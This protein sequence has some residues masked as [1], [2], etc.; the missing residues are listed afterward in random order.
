MIVVRYSEI[1]LKGTRARRMMENRL[2]S[3]IR[4]GLLSAGESADFRWERGRLFLDGYSRSEV[5][6]DVLRRTMGVKSFSEVTEMKFSKPSEIVDMAIQLYSGLLSGKKF[7]V[8]SRRAGGQNFTSMNLNLLVGDALFPYSDGVDL[9]H[10]E[11]EVNIELRD[12]RA[13]FFSGSHEGPGGLPIGSEGKLVALVSGGIDSP[14]AAWMAMKRGSPLEFVFVSLAHPVDTMDFLWVMK[15]L[16][17]RWVHGFDPVIHI[18]DGSAIVRELAGRDD[19]LAPSVT[20]K[21]IL[22][23]TAQRIAMSTGAYGIVTGESLGQVS[24]QTP[25]NLLVINSGIDFPVYRPLAGMDKDEITAMA[26]RIGTFPESNK[27]EFCSLFSRNSVMGVT[28]DQVNHDIGLFPFVDNLLS[29]ETVIRG[30]TLDEYAS[31][32]PVTDLRGGEFGPDPVVVD[33]RGIEKFNEWHY[34][35]SLHARM[36]DVRGIVDKFGR[37]KTYVFY[38]QKGLQSAYAASE[39]RKMGAIAYYLTSEAIRRMTQSGKPNISET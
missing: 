20:F 5:V 31:S 18:L 26:R 35:G 29:S 25:E 28:S 2:R 6:M 24:S 19:Y 10:P 39:A 9:E 38:C 14:V 37:G 22:Y 21:R 30:S 4:Q 1:G 32:I 15:R 17:S 3:N 27:G 36:G 33:L 8:R 34:P 23:S 13:Y 16:I 7:A 12:N 11:V